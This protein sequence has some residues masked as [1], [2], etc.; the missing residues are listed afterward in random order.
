[1][2]SPIALWLKRVGWK[3]V[4]LAT[5]T[6]TDPGFVSQVIRGVRKPNTRIRAMLAEHAPE[7]LAAQDRYMELRRGKL[8]AS[9]KAA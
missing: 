2:H 9:L 6:Q 3:Q 8:E 5:L 4:D 1:M 7:V